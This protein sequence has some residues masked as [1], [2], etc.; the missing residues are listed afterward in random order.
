M[1][2]IKAAIIRRYFLKLKHP[3]AIDNYLCKMKPQTHE[4]EK[5]ESSENEL[6]CAP[7]KY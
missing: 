2:D 3:K 6:Y 4:A 1:P 5:T 7:A